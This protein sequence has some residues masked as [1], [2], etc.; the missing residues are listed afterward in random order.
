MKRVPQ[1]QPT[2]G[3]THL[4]KGSTLNAIL[5]ALHARTPLDA[6]QNTPAGHSGVGGGGGRR[7]PMPR[8]TRYDASKLYVLTPTTAADLAA[9][10]RARLP[11]AAAV[12]DARGWLPGGELADDAAGGGLSKGVNLSG[13]AGDIALFLALMQGATPKG[14]VRESTP[15]G[16]RME[17]VASGIPRLAQIFLQTQDRWAEGFFCTGIVHTGDIYATAIQTTVYTS[18][19]I[20]TT[21]MQPNIGPHVQNPITNP[22]RYSCAS[23]SSTDNR[24]PGHIY[25]SVVSTS[26]SYSG[27]VTATGALDLAASSVEADPAG[28]VDAYSWSWY[29]DTAAPDAST[30]TQP[31]AHSQSSGLGDYTVH[32]PQYRWKNTGSLHIGVQWTESGTTRE[33]TVAPGDTSSW[34]IADLPAGLGVYSYITAVTLA[35]PPSAGP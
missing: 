28:P 27:V 35:Y 13:G 2:P 4:F 30:F 18:G 34:Y 1:P 22:T 20:V 12:R 26:T 17:P 21:T 15:F 16:Y 14:N 23:T 6:A 7:P 33:I 19:T 3:A 32:R 10:L 25:G 8:R 24:I 31:L 9:C 29:E 5:A 11:A